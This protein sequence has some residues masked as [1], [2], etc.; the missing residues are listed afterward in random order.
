MKR[1]RCERDCHWQSAEFIFLIY[2]AHT[3]SLLLLLLWLPLLLLSNF[4]LFR[5]FQFIRLT[6]KSREENLFAQC[7]R[8]RESINRGKQCNIFHVYIYFRTQQ[9]LLL[10]WHC[11]FYHITHNIRTTVFSLA[12]SELS[13]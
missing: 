1:F 5:I 9:Y 3:V 10:L 7:Q 4:I 6:T 11:F 8:E 12:I 13:V 2:P